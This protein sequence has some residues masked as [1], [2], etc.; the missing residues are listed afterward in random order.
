MKEKQIKDL[1]CETFGECNLLPQM[2]SKTLFSDQSLLILGFK[3]IRPIN[4]EIFTTTE[5]GMCGLVCV[6]VCSL[7]IGIPV[8]NKYRTIAGHVLFKHSKS[9]QRC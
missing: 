4:A 3:V 8:A 2:S 1:I 6:R 7:M 9:C 5:V